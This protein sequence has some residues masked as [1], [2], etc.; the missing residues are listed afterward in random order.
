M[1]T[2]KA[3]VAGVI[4]KDVTELIGSVI[5]EMGFQL[6]DVE[7][8]SERGRW[9]L[10]VYVDKADGITLDDCANVS[11]EIGDLIDV[12][13]IIDREYVLEVSSP[14]LNKP[15]KNESAF[16]WAIDKKIKVTI[17]TPFDGRKIF[18]GYLRDFQ[19]GILRIET[20]SGFFSLTLADVKKARLVSEFEDL[21]ES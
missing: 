8:L 2:D 13:D 6:V 20:E 15:L 5:D 9:I 10:R 7:F 19:K 14:G 16:L 21:N 17:H 11:R 3:D 12:K 4:I 1:A 18:I